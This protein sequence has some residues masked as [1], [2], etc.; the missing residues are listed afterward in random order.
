M[1]DWVY[2]ENYLDFIYGILFSPFYAATYISGQFI[3]SYYYVLASF[4][5]VV[6]VSA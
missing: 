4:T 5:G 3:Y 6:P 2:F 1:F